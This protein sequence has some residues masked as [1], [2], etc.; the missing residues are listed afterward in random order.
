MVGIPRYVALEGKLV[1]GKE[2]IRRKCI[3]KLISCVHIRMGVI[4]KPP[5]KKLNGV[6]GTMK[7]KT[8]DMKNKSKLKTILKKKILKNKNINFKNK[9]K[10]LIK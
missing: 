3:S 2:E 1:I 9:R 5:I 7:I 6:G 4:G 8:K 10:I